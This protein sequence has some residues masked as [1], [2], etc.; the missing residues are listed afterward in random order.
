MIRSVSSGQL[1]RL[2]AVELSSIKPQLDAH[3]V[4]LIGVG[5]EELGLE[6]FQEGKFFTGELFIDGEKK[7]YKDLG[8][9]RYGTLSVM[10]SLLTKEF[11]SAYAKSNAKGIKGNMKGDGLQT[12]GMLIVTSESKV[13]LSH[14]QSAP[15]DHVSN[16]A[17]LKALGID[18]EPS[19]E[20][21]KEEGAASAKPKME[22]NED[23][24]SLPPK[25]K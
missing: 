7:C 17:I 19:Q 15:G 9:K 8:F 12:G 18:A 2:W 23:V 24:C 6:E 21:S 14:A 1:C 13:L 25:E 4:A 10:A 3:N 20:T 5:L 16:E 22:C 11:R